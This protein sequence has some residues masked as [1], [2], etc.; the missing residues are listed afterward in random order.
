MVQSVY[1]LSYISAWD[2]REIG[3]R[4]DLSV[5]VSPGSQDFF[6]CPERKVEEPPEDLI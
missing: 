6:A 4:P 2:Y 3:G 5:R 1:F